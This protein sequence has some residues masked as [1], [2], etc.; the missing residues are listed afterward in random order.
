M[1]EGLKELI[2][3]NEDQAIFLDAGIVKGEYPEPEI[4]YIGKSWK[5]EPRI[6]I[7]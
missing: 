1:E 6:Q 7:I 2:K 3:Q 5:P 4:V